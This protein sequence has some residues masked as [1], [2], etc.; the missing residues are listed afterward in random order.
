M[1]WYVVK[2]IPGHENKVKRTLDDAI[3]SKGFSEI[4]PEVLLLTEQVTEVKRGKQ[5]TAEKRMWPGYLLIRL[6]LDDESWSFV[7]QIPG[8]K[9]F[10]L[11]GDGKP[12]PLSEEEVAFMVKERDNR[13][14]GV[15]HYNSVQI[16][17]IVKINDG[18]FATFHGAVTEVDPAKGHLKVSVSIFGR[19]T[20]VHLE[21]WQVEPYNPEDAT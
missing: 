15:V 8:V 13:Q 16:G 4:I 10:A 19:D 5:R 21:L 20:P 7:K 18:S 17:D 12:S 1:R 2:V 9:D 6:K 11:G 14:K 3:Q